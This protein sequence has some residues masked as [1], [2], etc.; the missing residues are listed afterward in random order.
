MP[1]NRDIKELSVADRYQ[2]YQNAVQ[3]PE[4]DIEFFEERFIEAHG[5]RPMRLRE[6]FAGAA[7]LS[8]TWATSD[9][10]RSALAVDLDPEPVAWGFKH[11][12]DHGNHPAADRVQQIIGDVREPHGEDFD[13]VCAMNFSFC[14]LQ[15]RQELRE[16]L[17][18][19]FFS[20]VDE[21]VLFLELCGG[22]EVM[23]EATEERVIEGGTYIWEQASFN[24]INH[25]LT[26]YIHFVLENGTRLDRAFEYTWRL[27]S[28]PEIRELLQEVG[29]T[30]SEVY[31]EAVN[32]DGEG[33]GEYHNTESE[34][35]QESWLV[36]IIGYR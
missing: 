10:E 33:T 5:H 4:T 36:Y 8:T 9:P 2:L 20:L 15:E 22:T 27:W 18:T 11:N 14:I 16:Y 12:L 19:A 29:F 32:E 1:R 6:D 21:G 24:P 26:C 23:T 25:E 13:V 3:A 17:K 34:Q 7:F 28:I 30:S 35:N 31:W